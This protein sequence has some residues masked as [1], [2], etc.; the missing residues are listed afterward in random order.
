MWLK[1]KDSTGHIETPVPNALSITRLSSDRWP[2]SKCVCEKHRFTAH[3]KLSGFEYRFSCSKIE[4]EWR[5]LGGG[6]WCALSGVVYM[7]PKDEISQ[8]PS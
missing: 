2:G 3:T 5:V 1:A 6:F 7:D 4:H 8:H